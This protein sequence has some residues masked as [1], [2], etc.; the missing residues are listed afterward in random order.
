[1]TLIDSGLQTLTLRLN[2]KQRNRFS[3]WRSYC[4]FKGK[5]KLD[6]LE[7]HVRCGWVWKVKKMAGFSREGHRWRG[8]YHVW[9]TETGLPSARLCGGLL[10]QGQ[11]VMARA[12]EA[13]AIVVVFI[14]IAGSCEA[15]SA[16]EEVGAGARHSGFLFWAPAADLEFTT[17]ENSMK[18]SFLDRCPPSSLDPSAGRL[19]GQQLELLLQHLV[20][21]HT[22]PTR[23]QTHHLNP[24]WKKKVGSHITSLYSFRKLQSWCGSFS[25]DRYSWFLK[26]SVSVGSDR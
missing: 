13:V 4:A 5:Q 20:I 21:H 17:R 26:Y 16:G 19:Q 11:S 7:A 14:W 22:K 8:G 24:R 9:V 12:G 10:G 23:A 15:G 25:G 2:K 3:M 6:Q 1:M 18:K